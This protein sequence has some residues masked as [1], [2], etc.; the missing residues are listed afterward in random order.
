MRASLLV[1]IDTG[2]GLRDV[3]DPRS[4]LAQWF[5]T[6]VKLELRDGRLALYQKTM[7][8]DH[9]CRV[10][11]QGRLRALQRGLAGSVTVFQAVG[12]AVAS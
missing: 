9:S 4:R 3:A 8:K 7:E 5:L 10:F 11:K 2:Y 1:L 12:V 6:L